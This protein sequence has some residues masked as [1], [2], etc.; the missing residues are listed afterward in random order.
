MLIL[1]AVTHFLVDSAALILAPL[2]PLLDNQIQLAN[3]GILWMVALWSI[4]TSFGQFGIACIADRF[5]C[6]WMTWAGPAVA[7]ACMSC[8]GWATSTW[9][10]ASLLCL[11]GLGVAAF[12]PEAAANAGNCLPERRSQAMAVFAL[13][14]YLGQFFGPIYSGWITE[15][16]HLQ[17]LVWSMAPGFAWLVF[18]CAMLHSRTQICQ[19][20]S[21]PPETSLL[22][23]KTSTV[24]LLTETRGPVSLLILIGTLRVIA[25]SG[26]PLSL[27]F[28]LDPKGQNPTQASFPISAMYFGI[29]AGGAS[30]FFLKPTQERRIMWSL[31]ICAAPFLI[32]IPFARAHWMPL[33]VGLS[34]FCL[35]VTLPILI[36]YGQRLIPK[37]QRVASSL[38]MGVTWGAG[39]LLVPLVVH[40]LKA[41]NLETMAFV[42]YGICALLSG[43]LCHGLPKLVHDGSKGD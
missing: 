21:S 43:L 14:G 23:T 29:G 18:L 37:G 2:W 38:T 17:S 39:G 30:T 9:A 27:A 31:P 32:L 28:L 5:S 6:R 36:S 13:G 8:L 16:Y 34:G 35:G 22:E 3:G 4:A 24:R 19:G 20:T 10:L 11:A 12:H 1:L 7:V 41:R 33:T 25:A 42:L 40:F 26:V 15:H